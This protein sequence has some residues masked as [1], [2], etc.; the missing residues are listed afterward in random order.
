MFLSGNGLSNFR[1]SL[2]SV[3][4]FFVDCGGRIQ[5]K[6]GAGPRTYGA[7]ATQEPL[8]A[9]GTT[10]PGPPGFAKGLRK[11]LSTLVVRL[12][13]P[14]GHGEQPFLFANICSREREDSS[15]IMFFRGIES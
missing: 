9:L 14:V 12:H 15:A 8:G 7:G 1:L 3:L 6:Q 13:S 4:N 2:A 10:P 11:K 5:K